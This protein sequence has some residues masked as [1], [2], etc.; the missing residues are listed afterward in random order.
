MDFIHIEFLLPGLIL[1]PV[2]A[3][4]QDRPTPVLDQL[5]TSARLETDSRPMSMTG[6]STPE[7]VRLFGLE[8]PCAAATAP[9]ALSVDD[10]SWDRTGFWLHADPVHLRADRDRL[11]LFDS[12]ALAISADEAQHLVAELNAHF[13][14]DALQLHAPVPERWYLRTPEPLA[15]QTQ[16]VRSVHGATL[17]DALP[18]GPQAKRWNRW[19]NEAQMLMHHSPVNQA[20][21]QTGRVTING[22]WLSG[23]G[24]YSP[25]VGA[26]DVRLVVAGDPL[27]QGLA[28]A[29]GMAVAHLT[30]Q[31][32]PQRLAEISSGRVVVIDE[33]LAAA[34]RQGD[35]SAWTEALHQLDHQLQPLAAWLF[36]PG[37]S[38]R[39]RAWSARLY[40]GA[41][42]RL[43]P[44]S[45]NGWFRFAR[46]RRG[47]LRALR[48]ARSG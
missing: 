11:R 20:R 36:T 29:A 5:L 34:G 37:R 44:P 30:D 38:S 17:E 23:G 6:E 12:G 4:E 33:R 48:E 16:P 41:V 32:L 45:S 26:E 27:A 14:A 21:A 31:D 46:A 39:R 22:L 40:D 1:P 19:L 10:P 2:R 24:Q 18:S 13:A 43:S 15:L 28:Q 3:P 9:Y 7:L 8:A 47:G 25:L 35:E 42:W